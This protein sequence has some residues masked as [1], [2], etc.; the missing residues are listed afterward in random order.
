MVAA[1][2]RLTSQTGT[3][4]AFDRELLLAYAKNQNAIALVI[5]LLAILIAGVTSVWA[6][7]QEVALW[8]TGVLIGNGILTILCRRYEQLNTRP[9]LNVRL[10]E[11]RFY[12]AEFL[13]GVLW[14]TLAFIT[15]APGDTSP[16]IFM[17]AVMI[18][19]LAMRT[20]T[21]SNMPEA[22]LA[23]TI[24]VTLAMII[25]L[26]MVADVLHLILAGIA[27]GA[28]IFFMI[29]SRQFHQTVLIMFGLR[30]EKDS[31]IAELEQAK[32]V[33]DEA[34]RRAEEA[35]L[36]KSRFLATM[37]HELRTP[38]NA[39]LGFSEVLKDELLGK[40]Q[41]AAYKEY[42][43]DIHKSGQHLLNLIN[44]ILDLSRIEAGRFEL[45]EEA[46][47]LAATAED[48][49]HLLKL[50]ANERGMTI[51]ENFE[52]D[53]PKIW[54]DER[55]VRQIILNLL[56][57]AIKFTP[58][59]GEITVTVGWTAGGGQYLSIRDTGPG[60]PQEEIP[61]VLSSFGRGSLAHK[62]AD[63]GTG[64]GLP[65]VVK[66]MELHGGTFDIRTKLREGT[67]VIVI[68]PRARVMKALPPVPQESRPRRAGRAA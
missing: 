43:F 16:V 30:A 63:E 47:S 61:T 9:T 59:G 10:W 52:P 15:V 48:C 35:N 29:L 28:Q 50:R 45:K 26:A 6:P 32:A 2:E 53:L 56:G 66:L 18:V 68:F 33:S 13:N 24:P 31:L 40:H 49:R 27:A 7:W 14:A 23:G 5:P 42:S 58:H 22:A 51:R 41:I 20:L 36:A 17:F 12:A 57:N 25:R 21:A 67:E 44:E 11:R 34:R 38:L 19:I 62:N 46:V 39:I 37:S 64:L 8:L 55:S 65:I 3:K 54:A 4:P 60:I 1:R